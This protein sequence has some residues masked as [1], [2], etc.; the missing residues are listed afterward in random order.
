MFILDDFNT[1][2]LDNV[3]PSFQQYV[4]IPTRWA[5]ILDMCYGNIPDAFW[6][7]SYPPLGLADH[8][9]ICLLP[10]YWQELKCYKPQCYS[11]PQ[12]LEDAI[13]HLQGSLTCTDL[14][15]LMVILMTESL[16]VQIQYQC[17]NRS[18]VVCKRTEYI[19]CTVWY[20]GSKRWV[21]SS[22]VSPSSVGSRGRG[23]APT[24]PDVSWARPLGLMASQQGCWRPVSMN[25]HQCSIHSSVNP[26]GL[27][28][29]HLENFYHNSHT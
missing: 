1:C 27:L 12:W 28:L 17:N 15:V 20:T 24:Q 7:C 21:C 10:L 3:L 26:I 13:A 29:Y 5:N 23:M 22:A 14:R 25:S 18:R 19:L 16:R 11:A 4:K 2:R 8:N 6:V 9:V